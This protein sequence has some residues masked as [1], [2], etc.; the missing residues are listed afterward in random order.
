MLDTVREQVRVRELCVCL[1]LMI[2]L[3]K[4]KN[5][6]LLCIPS[7]YK[8]KYNSRLK[9]H[10][11]EGKF[12]CHEVG[13]EAPSEGKLMQGEEGRSVHTGQQMSLPYPRVSLPDALLP[14][15]HARQKQ[16]PFI[17]SFNNE[18]FYGDSG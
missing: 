2:L 9:R 15:T 4:K 16:L 1:C 3:F 5:E 13:P 18:L 11:R 17:H 12:K 7:V 6:K 14:N 8:A 10:L